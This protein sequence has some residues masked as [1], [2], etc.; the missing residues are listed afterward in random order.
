MGRHIGVSDLWL[1][2]TTGSFWFPA[3]EGFD[4]TWWRS[5]RRVLH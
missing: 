3:A 1:G 5:S 2:G 4:H